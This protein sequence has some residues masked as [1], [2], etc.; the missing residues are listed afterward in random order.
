MGNSSNESRQQAQKK[1]TKHD[2]PFQGIIKCGHCG[3]TITSEQKKGKYVYYHCS[4]WKGSCRHNGY[5]TQDDLAKLFSKAFG[6]IRLDAK[7]ARKIE[8][9]MKAFH[10]TEIND[11]EEAVKRL[12]KNAMALQARI[13]KAYQDKLDAENRRRNLEPQPY[14]NGQR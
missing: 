9:E 10:R 4:Q 13:D 5:I 1:H 12:N 11:R 8:S 3:C 7:K 14:S 6:A 2:F